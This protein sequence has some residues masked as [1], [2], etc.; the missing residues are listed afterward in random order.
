VTTFLEDLG[1]RWIMPGKFGEVVPK[2][3]VLASP[4]GKRTEKPDFE[5][6]QIWYAYGAQSPAGAK[7][8]AE[9]N[10]HNKVGYLAINQG[11]NLTTSL[12]RDVT[13]E[14]HPEY[15]ALVAGRRQKSQVCTTHPDVLR[16][17]T[18]TVNDY[19]DKHPEMLSYSLCP[20]DNTKFCECARCRALDVEGIDPFTGAQI[21]SDRYMQFINTIARGIQTKHPGKMITTY[22]YVNYTDPPR[23]VE[24]DPHVVVIFTTSVFCSIHG[25][26]DS[27]CASRMKMKSLLEAWTRK[28]SRVYVYE[29]DPIPFNAELPCPLYG[30]RMREMPVYRSVGVR[31]FSFESHQS[32]ATLS[33]NHYVSAKMMW[34]SNADGKAI[35]KDY[36]D[37]F[38]GPAGEAMLAYYTAQEEAFGD[39]R[40]QIQWSLRDIPDAFSAK[41]IAR[42]ETAL[43]TAEKAGSAS[44]YRERLAMVR[45]AYSYLCR[46]LDARRAAAGGMYDEY[47]AHIASAEKLIGDMSNISEN[48]IL[49]KVAREYLRKLNE[50]TLSHLG[51]DMGLVTSWWLIGPFDN[52]GWKGHSKAYPPEHH[53]DLKG[54]YQGVTGPVRWRRYKAPDGQSYVDLAAVMKPKD[55][56]CAYGLTYVDSPTAR[57]VQL[58]VGSNDS[59]AIFLNGKKVHDHQIDRQALV[60]QDVVPVDLQAGRNT[61]LI[62]IGQTGFA[63]GFFFRITD[64]NGDRLTD[65]RFGLE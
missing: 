65:L 48:F 11:H 7:D 38:F 52:A 50:E 25:I 2:R 26:G 12:P 28:A 58:R 43:S 62:K 17:I 51:Q 36:C 16:L 42:M 44:P 46:Y 8:L 60:D 20:D 14:N 56:V 45:L 53:I 37:S 59:V 5:Y 24:V 29:Y 21:V 31:G 35:L 10:R 33:P 9:W 4:I 61:I 47:K 1:V 13:L 41:I 57:R 54:E 63:W 32:W 23:K 55:W 22:A 34:N 30:Q 19:F 39:Y 40:G 64:M 49:A 3:E 15:Y 18:Q 6:R 27:H